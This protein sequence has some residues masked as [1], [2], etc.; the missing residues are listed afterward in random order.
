MQA[1]DEVKFI[2]ILESI[3]L[4]DGEKIF[5]MY[6]VSHG[7]GKVS[8][9]SSET[10]LNRT[11]SYHIVNALL[12]KGLIREE[13]RVSGKVLFPCTLQEL[14]KKIEEKQ[15]AI[16]AQ[17]RSLQELEAY[18]PAPQAGESTEPKIRKFTGITGVR[19][20][21]KDIFAG[22]GQTGQLC[23]YTN[24]KS[25]RRYFSAAAHKD[26]VH[27]RVGK[28]I[29]IRVL[30]VDNPEGRKLLEHKEKLLRQVRFL[31]PDFQFKA[32]MYLYPSKIC[33]LD[34]QE[35]IIA[36]VIESKELYVIHQYMFETLWQN[37]QPGQE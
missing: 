14:Q 5:F 29:H 24:Q 10:G 35:D 21:M 23:L 7:S 3:G 26:F 6:L 15:H 13:N 25:E 1:H 32:E 28:G 12:E 2:N 11:N 37:Q 8:Q 27:Q 18:F 19:Q 34:L 30:A 16:Q 31:P 36:L 22:A 17:K 4:T 20:M 33:M 9:I